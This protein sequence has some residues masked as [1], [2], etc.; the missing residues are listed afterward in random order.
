MLAGMTDVIRNPFL[1]LG[2]VSTAGAALSCSSPAI[3][4]TAAAEPVKEKKIC[5]RQEVTGSILGLRAVCHTKSE[6]QR[7]DRDDEN[8]AG[9]ML[10]R[11]RQLQNSGVGNA[12]SGG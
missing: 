4:Q 2:I 3:A 5:R 10:D 8:G 9:A 7:I 11:D 12:R 6:W 1:M